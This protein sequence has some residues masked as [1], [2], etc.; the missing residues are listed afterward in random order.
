MSNTARTISLVVFSFVLSL[1]SYSAP[2]MGSVGLANPA[3]EY[4]VA[5]GGLFGLREGDQGQFGICVL[6]NGE[7]VDAWEYFR[8]HLKGEPSVNDATIANP[9]ATFCASIGGTYSLETSACELPDGSEVDAWEMLR[10]AHATSASLV[11]PAA[12]YCIDVGGTYEIRE[13]ELRQFGV[14]SLPDGNKVD[15]WALYRENN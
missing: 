12:S 8:E 5:S 4:C 14:C 2:G 13:G 10:A 6:S 11:N 9:A 3:A 15:A 7:E 1:S